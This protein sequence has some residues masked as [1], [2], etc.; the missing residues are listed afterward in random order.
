[1][2]RSLL[3]PSS[4]G[5]ALMKSIIFVLSFLIFDINNNQTVNAFYAP[6]ASRR[7][8]MTGY[9][10][11]SASPRKMH[12]SQ[13]HESRANVYYTDLEMLEMKRRVLTISLERDDGTRRTYVSKW[14]TAHANKPNHYEGTR[15][16][17]LWDATVI[18]LGEEFQQKL[19]INAKKKSTRPCSS[20]Q[21]SIGKNDKGDDSNEKF[22][23]WAF[24]DMLVQTKTLINKLQIPKEPNHRSMYRQRIIHKVDNRIDES[25]FQ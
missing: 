13:L 8:T 14:I 9:S 7:I 2:T 6:A 12:L 15:L 21:T 10:S 19:R 5:A 4:T 24:V 17:H 1:M 25:I 22:T 18:Q 3:T 23:L 11:S 16:I 20:K